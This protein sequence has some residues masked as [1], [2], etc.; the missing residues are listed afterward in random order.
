MS[1]SERFNYD[2]IT[3]GYAKD[4]K[5]GIIAECKGE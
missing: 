3:A 4:F 1:K 2:D 5:E